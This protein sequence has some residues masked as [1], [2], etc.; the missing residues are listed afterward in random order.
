MKQDLP[1]G[2]GF[3][4]TVVLSTSLL[5]SVSGT[6]VVIMNAVD[7]D[8]ISFSVVCRSIAVFLSVGVV[9]SG[10]VVFDGFDGIVDDVSGI[11]NGLHPSD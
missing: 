11:I 8:S 4:F 5:M 3:C 1:S 9:L 7:L 6:M 2:L 10:V